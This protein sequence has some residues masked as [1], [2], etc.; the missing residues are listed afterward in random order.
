MD[1]LII[2]IALNDTNLTSNPQKL[3]EFADQLNLELIKLEPELIKDINYQ[4]SDKIMSN[5]YDVFFENLPIFLEEQDYQ[6]IDT[7]GDQR[8]QR[9]SKSP[10]KPEDS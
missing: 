4:V 10:D 1:K 9:Q 7:P 2:N 3:I 6:E 8:T 5:V